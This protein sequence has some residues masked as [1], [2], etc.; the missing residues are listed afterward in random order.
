MRGN[1]A[2]VFVSNF[3]DGRISVIDLPDLGRPQGA[4]LVAHLGPQQL[5]LTRGATSPGCLASLA[6][7][8]Q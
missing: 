8:T 1:A 2:R 5:C 6:Q 3:G 4:R 7:V